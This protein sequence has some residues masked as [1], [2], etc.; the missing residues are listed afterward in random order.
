MLGRLELYG[1]PTHGVKIETKAKTFTLYLLSSSLTN[2]YSVAQLDQFG[3]HTSF[4][5]NLSLKLNAI[6]YIC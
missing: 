2:L 1:P 5:L 4:L 6:I 3:E